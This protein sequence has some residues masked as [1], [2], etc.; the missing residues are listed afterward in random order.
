MK[1]LFSDADII[2]VDKPGGLLA[3]PGRGPAKQDCVVSRTRR[4][5][6]D[7]PVQ[8]A[9][10][11]LDMYTSGIM[12]LARNKEAHRHLVRQ[13]ENRE[14]EKKYVALLEGSIVQ[15]QGRIELKFRLDINNRPYQVY[16]PVHGK[17]GIT[18]WQKTATENQRTR[19]LFTPLTGRTHQLR[20][21][22]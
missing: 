10:H 19:V 17:T 14:V 21:H 22:A 18:L 13:F 3:V 2:V 11:R 8:P 4:L 9:V 1:I 12:V 5:F 7:L 20:L 6:P 16:D 15:D